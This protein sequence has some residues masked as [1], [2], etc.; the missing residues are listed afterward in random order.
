[1]AVDTTNQV[2]SI[3]WE[4]DAVR[5]ARSRPYRTPSGHA[6]PLYVDAR[7]ALADPRSR[8]RI[9]DA[10]IEAV[11]AVR[12]DADIVVAAD[13]DGIPI[14]ACLADKLSLPMAYVRARPKT[15]GLEHQI[16]GKVH[17]GAKALLVADAVSA[18][19]TVS[20]AIDT[21]RSVDAETVVCTAIYGDEL[22]AVRAALDGQGVA[23]VVLSDLESIIAAG[24]ES[25]RL[26]QAQAGEW[27]R[28]SAATPHPPPTW[29]VVPESRQA[30]AAALLDTG[31][32]SYRIDPPYRLVSGLFAPIYVDC[33]LL[34]SH[35]EARATVIGFMQRVI[36]SRIG[37]AN[38]DA[39]A[40]TTTAGLPY[41]AVLAERLGRPFVYVKSEAEPFGRMSRV[42][43]RIEPGQQIVVIED[44]ITTGS[45]V[46]ATTASLRDAG[47]AVATCV[48]I[49]AYGFEEARRSFADASL[50]L[51]H[52]TD[53]DTLLHVALEKG[54][55]IPHVDRE[56][57][58]WLRD[59]KSWSPGEV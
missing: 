12:G 42:E 34:I 59:P 32:V 30:V 55:I 1:V 4:V 40:G 58:A 9:V 37:L 8:G 24:L 35:R 13:A 52:L 17:P 15:H 20:Q 29:E 27:R 31:A 41:A 26:T 54:I 22:G 43:G 2:A 51:F 46:L 25:A 23:L 28:L 45:S 16:E 47:A 56:V 50:S 38:V 53:S 10:L 44:H 39:I 6:A 57:R 19:S 3:L 7:R 21:L 5:A 48:S 49:L 36:E 18:G 11:S 33:R 14:A